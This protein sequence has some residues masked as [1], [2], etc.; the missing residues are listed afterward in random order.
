MYVILFIDA[1]A[2][3]PDTNSVS[4]IDLPDD[5]FADRN[6]LDE[7]DPDLNLLSDV[8]GGSSYYLSPD[9]NDLV[10]KSPAFKNGF[11]VFH[12]NIRSAPANMGA[13]SAFLSTL[14]FTFSIV[15]LT[16]TWL[17][18]LNTSAYSLP[19]YSS[20]GVHRENR[21][22]GGVMLLLSDTIA[23]KRR[24]DFDLMTDHCECI[25]AEILDMKAFSVPHHTSKAIIGCLYRPPNSD[26][27]QFIQ[28]LKSLL[29]RVKQERKTCYLIGDF[30]IHMNEIANSSQAQQ[31]MDLLYSHLFLPLIDRPSR[32]TSSNSSLI[33]NIFTNSLCTNRISGLLYTD[34]SD[35]LP[36][37]FLSAPESIQQEAL[38]TKRNF[39]ERNKERFTMMLLDENWEDVLSYTTVNDCLEAFHVKLDTFFENSFPLITSPQK[40][41]RKE[42]PWITQELK[43][44]I[45]R[46]NKLYLVFHK[47]PTLFNEIQYKSLKRIVRCALRR[48]QKEYY[49][50]QLEA[51]R[52]NIKK[53]WEI[54]NDLMGRGKKK[55]QVTEINV[56]NRTI[57]NPHEIAEEMNLHFATVGKKK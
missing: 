54:L 28:S 44:L 19:G 9:F 8:Y 23:F 12:L 11:S 25:F 26:F 20:I 57:A 18:E 10:T 46:K 29:F 4:L 53:T 13:L 49:H 27:D 48:A 32:I 38:I 45:R 51:N 52:N 33:D 47:R 17:N 34:I 16:E 1:M 56:E 30:N 35:H 15:G 36:I 42:K 37:F 21:R 50:A 14:D 3:P 7:I 43:R 22:G 55:S 5:S 31:F 6:F 41:K 2:G 24:T 40:R 39:S